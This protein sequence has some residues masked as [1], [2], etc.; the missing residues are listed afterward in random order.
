MS[1]YIE[2]FYKKLQ[3][4][5]LDTEYSIVGKHHGFIVIKH[6]KCGEIFRTTSD[7]FFNRNEK[8]FK[9]EV[10]ISTASNFKVIS[11]TGDS[12]SNYIIEC[13][14]CNHRFKDTR[15][16][17][18]LKGFKCRNCNPER[19]KKSFED[20][21]LELHNIYGDDIITLDSKYIPESKGVMKFKCNLCGNT[22]EKTSSH[23]LEGRSC[24]NC[25]TNK[26]KKSTDQFKD[27]VIYY[28]GD[29]IS[30]ISEYNGYNKPI[31]VRHN[32]CNT[33][34]V[35]T[36]RDILRSGKYKCINARLS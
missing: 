36:P 5:K 10:D 23:I 30:V 18:R 11:F 22:F 16:R 21:K 28:F 6:N 12:R 2:D 32:K 15:S 34:F 26:W 9:C 25:W 8:C 3:N 19:K 7:K 33:E 17:F 20:F 1:N 35:R 14:K 27:E 4:S 13:S 29:S 31:T 24:P